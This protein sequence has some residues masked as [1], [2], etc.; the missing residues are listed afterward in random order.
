MDKNIVVI[1]GEYSEDIT[2]MTRIDEAE[3]KQEGHRTIYNLN[4]RFIA[5]LN[6][7]VPVTHFNLR[8]IE[9]PRNGKLI[10]AEAHY[11]FRKKNEILE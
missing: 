3:S 5:P 8:P 7:S 1:G 6:K 4:I 10:D 2:R 11:F 9:Q